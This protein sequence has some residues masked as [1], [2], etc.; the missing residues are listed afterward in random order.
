MIAADSHGTIT[1]AC[2]AEFSIRIGSERPCYGAAG[3]PFFDGI[4]DE[5]DGVR[6]D[7]DHIACRCGARLDVD[8]LVDAVL[9][10]VE[11]ARGDL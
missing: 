11:D 6:E 10:A 3:G 8:A 2:G 5:P 9:A 4:E 7:G 1:H